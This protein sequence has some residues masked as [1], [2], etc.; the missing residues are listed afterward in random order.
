MGEDVPENVAHVRF[1]PSVVDVDNE[2]FYNCGKL[3]EVVLNVGLREIGKFV[4]KQ[5][6]FVP[7]M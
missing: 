4:I 1:H 7:K 5:Y 3:I 2:A 6:I